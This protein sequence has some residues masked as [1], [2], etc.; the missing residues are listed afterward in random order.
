MVLSYY[1]CI[2]NSLEPSEVIFLIIHFSYIEKKHL[3]FLMRTVCSLAKQGA[4]N[5]LYG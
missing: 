2:S 5:L 4:R 1:F 3:A